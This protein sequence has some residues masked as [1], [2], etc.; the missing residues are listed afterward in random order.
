MHRVV[1][2]V[3]PV[4]STFELGC[5]VEVFGTRRPGVPAHY[6]FAVCTPRPGPVPTSAGYTMS[7]PHGLPALATADTVIIPGWLP[8]T[9]VPSPAVL[10]ALRQ[11]HARGARLVTMCSGVFA[12]AATGL[13]DG[14]SA[15]SHPDRAEQLQRRYPRIRVESRRRFVDHGDVATSAGAGAGLDLFLHLVGRD[16]GAGYAAALARH[17]VLPPGQPEPPV[18]AAPPERGPALD[19]VLDWAEA[20]LDADLSVADLA[21]RLHVSTRTLARRFA[22]E[23][24]TSPGAWLLARRLARARDLLAGTDL[25]VEAVAARVGLRSAVNLRRRF[26][27]HVGTTPGAYRQAARG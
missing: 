18:T 4:Q 24:G 25:P 27:A 10:D 9:A 21:A 1:A 7:V 17:M 5:A 12:L 2:L 6:E 23:L 26:H 13:L 20:R 14:R 19:G 22:D 16:H 3:R 15:T 11:A 8:V